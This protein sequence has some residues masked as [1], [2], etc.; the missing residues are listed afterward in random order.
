MLFYDLGHAL[1]GGV[2]IFLL[3][4]EYDS[5]DRETSYRA[6]IVVKLELAIQ[7]VH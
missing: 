5:K 3:M 1:E 4:S 6:L 2:L 7:C